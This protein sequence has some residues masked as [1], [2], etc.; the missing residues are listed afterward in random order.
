MRSNLEMEIDDN[1]TVEDLRRK[2]RRFIFKINQEQTIIDHHYM[3]E[4]NGKKFDYKRHQK[5]IAKSSNKRMLKETDFEVEKLSTRLGLL[6]FEDYITVN[7]NVQNKVFYN[8]TCTCVLTKRRVAIEVAGNTENEHLL[9]EL[10]EKSSSLN[11]MHV[12]FGDC[13]VGH[14]IRGDNY[15]PMI[16][17]TYKAESLIIL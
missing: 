12:D 13:I 6:K 15:I 17:Q 2:I 7:D 5:K 3:I 11:E 10:S 14:Y 9:K 1:M 16:V 8:V 4:K